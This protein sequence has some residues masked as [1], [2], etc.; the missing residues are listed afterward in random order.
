[1]ASGLADAMRGVLADPERGK[2]IGNA[3]REWVLSNAT[4]KKRVSEILAQIGELP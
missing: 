4:W 2:A 1:D 3:A